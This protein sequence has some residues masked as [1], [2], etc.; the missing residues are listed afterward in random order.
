MR[1]SVQPLERVEGDRGRQPAQTGRVEHPHRPALRRGRPRSARPGRCGCWWRSPRPARP[2]SGRPTPRDFPTRGPPIRSVTSSIG[3][4][5]RSSPTRAT[6]VATSRVRMPSRRSRLCWR[7]LGRNTMAFRRT[8]N[9][10]AGGQDRPPG[11][12]P[13]VSSGSPRPAAH[14]HRRPRPVMPPHQPR[15][16]QQQPADRQQL[17]ALRRPMGQA[18]DREKPDPDQGGPP[19]KPPLPRPDHRTPPARDGRSRGLHIDQP[20]RP[21]RRV[22]QRLDRAGRH[23]IAAL[24]APDPHPHGWKCVRPDQPVQVLLRHAQQ[25]RRLRNRVRR[26]PVRSLA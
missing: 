17:A 26:N 7:R 25:R 5:T 12:H 1:G 2:G 23:D 16:Q 24:L 4:H 6:G 3:D 14:Q 9:R 20:A 21:G 15:N 13:V 8:A 22:Q 18:P 10:L 11:R 19:Q